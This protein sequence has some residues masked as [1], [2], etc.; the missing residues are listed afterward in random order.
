MLASS[1]RSGLEE[2]AHDGALAVCA[3]D[4][5]LVAWSGDIDRPFFIRSAA[6]P[7]QAAVS[8][9]SG[10]DL[11]PVELALASASH[12]GHPVH[13]GVAE[14]MLSKVDLG[15]DALQC[16]ASWPLSPE[17]ARV[18]ARFGE[19]EPR[20]IWHN[21]SGK[22]SGFLRAC[23]AA[24]W[25]TDSYL[26]PEHP[27]QRRI[28]DLMAEIGG[29]DPGPV[30]VDGCGA[31][32]FR[33]TALSM[34]KLFAALGSME[35]LGNVFTSMHRYP[36]LTGDAHSPDAEIA[37]SLHAVAKGGAAG[38]LG[39]SL[40]ADLGIG[41]KSWDGLGRMAAV[42]AV[43]ALRQMGRLDA[44]PGSVLRHVESPEVMGGGRAVGTV[45]PRLTLQ[46]A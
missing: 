24:G 41:V 11:S 40:H 30:G 36:A 44:H 35:R 8:Q 28:F 45:Q 18:W 14:S 9:E 25:D 27:L 15:A 26:E 20:R 4:G 1:V 21:C 38:C 23:V 12:R 32:V 5:S 29:L 46:L 2:T 3:S 33:T 10:A 17:A 7:F 43:A 16:P 39:V 37:K 6:K 31:P 13:V 22:H 19:R 42:G 34:A